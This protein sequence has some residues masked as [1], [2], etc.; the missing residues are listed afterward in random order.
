[1]ANDQPV[2][3][4]FI[5]AMW[6]IQFWNKDTQQWARVIDRPEDFDLT[7]EEAYQIISQY[8]SGRILIERW[9]SEREKQIAAGLS[10][11]TN[12]GVISTELA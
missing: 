6:G 1:M 5:M 9:M 2:R 4:P 7:I 10:A 3:K 8:R 12:G 11:K